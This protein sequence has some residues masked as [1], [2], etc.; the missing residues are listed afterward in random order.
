MTLR[1]FI[2]KNLIYNFWSFD[3]DQISAYR[4]INSD[5][6]EECTYEEMLDPFYMFSKEKVAFVTYDPRNHTMNI[7]LED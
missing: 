2:E 6:Y 7:F 5:S 3:P 1:D 4:L